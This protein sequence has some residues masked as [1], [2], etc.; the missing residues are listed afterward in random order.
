MYLF[1]FLFM[2]W[3]EDMTQAISKAL[4]ITSPSGSNSHTHMQSFGGDFASKNSLQLTVKVIALTLQLPVA[5]ITIGSLLFR[6]T[7]PLCLCPLVPL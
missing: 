2:I 3:A 7:F 6:K 4:P 5:I 1:I